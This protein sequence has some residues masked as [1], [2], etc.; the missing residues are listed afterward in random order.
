VAAGGALAL[1]LLLVLQLTGAFRTAD[2]D[3]GLPA[4]PP[5]QGGTPPVPPK[6]RNRHVNA[7]GMEF[8]LVPKGRSWL[9][10]GDG[11]P[12]EREIEVGADYYLGV[13]EVT[14]ADWEKVMA[15]PNPR[16]EF[17]RTGP[18]QDIIRRISDADLQRF[19]IDAVTWDECGV[20]VARLNEKAKEDGWVYRLPMNVEWEYACRGGPLASREESAFTYYLDEP[21]NTLPAALANISPS[22]LNRPC[23][24]GSY[25]PNRLGIHDMHGNVFEYCDDVVDE[26]EKPLRVLRGGC[27][28]DG[29]EFARAGS[30]SV[31]GP[32][33]A[34][35]GSGF[36]VARVPA[37]G[38]PV[39][40][41]DVP[42]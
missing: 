38:V 36:R 25:P 14:R 12:G 11:N 17:T 21:T 22:G 7:V 8:A 18:K 10:G 39:S 32:R 27:W 33:S 5:D 15:T 19:P 13:Y 4:V 41:R 6:D 42:R 20:F 30:N 24:V 26:A 34:Y 16:T 31:G 2:P 37:A 1:V 35:T 29:P 3:T 23:K 9:G 28:V 40:V